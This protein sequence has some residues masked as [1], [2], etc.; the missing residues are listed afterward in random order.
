[1][2]RLNSRSAVRRH[3]R[4]AGFVE[5]ELLM[6]ECCPNYLML[7]APL[8]LMGVGFER[9]VNSSKMFAALRVNILGHFSKA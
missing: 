6:R 5:E 1:M 2:Y 4:D 8:F 9:L 3:L 7:A